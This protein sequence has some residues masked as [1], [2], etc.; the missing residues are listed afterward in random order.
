MSFKG[1]FNA[2]WNES[3]GMLKGRSPVS[4]RDSQSTSLTL[5]EFLESKF[6]KTNYKIGFS[7]AFQVGTK[8]GIDPGVFSTVKKNCRPVYHSI[9][10][11]GHPR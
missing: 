11:P 9:N 4:R 8:Y 7:P 10:W 5:N 3:I 1:K 2:P 6:E